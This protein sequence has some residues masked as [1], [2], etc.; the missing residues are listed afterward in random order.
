MEFAVFITLSIIV[1]MTLLF[2]SMPKK[3]PIDS[4]NYWCQEKNKGLY[5]F[6][7]Y[8]I[9]KFAAYLLQGNDLQ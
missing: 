4:E 8:K 2:L 5:T 3:P 9:P 6:G 1:R 7:G